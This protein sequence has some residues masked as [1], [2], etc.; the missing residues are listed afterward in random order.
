MLLDPQ[1]I[2]MVIQS[3]NIVAG[4]PRDRELSAA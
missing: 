3:G 2:W 4:R 1:R